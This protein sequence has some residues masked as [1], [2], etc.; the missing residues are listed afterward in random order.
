MGEM[1]EMRDQTLASRHRGP[2]GRRETRALLPMKE[3]GSLD[4]KQLQML[5]ST[6][7]KR[8]GVKGR[9]CERYDGLPRRRRQA[10]QKHGEWPP[11]E[12]RWKRMWKECCAEHTSEEE[13]AAEAWEQPPGWVKIREMQ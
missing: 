9:C 5:R 1:H 4:S 6:R 2:G 11:R 12:C 8:C 10:R 13:A 7:W 3:A